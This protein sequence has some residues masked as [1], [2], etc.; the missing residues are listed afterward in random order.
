MEIQKLV[1]SPEGEHINDLAWDQ[2][3]GTLD[4]HVLEGEASKIEQSVREVVGEN[5]RFVEDVYSARELEAQAL[6]LAQS[7][8]D[9]GIHVVS[10]RTTENNSGLV[11]SVAESSTT[12][13][14]AAQDVDGLASAGGVPVVVETTAEDPAMATG[15]RWGDSSPFYGGARIYKPA[16]GYSCTSAFPVVAPITGGYQT[17]ILTADHCGAIGD[18]WRSGQANGNNW[19]L[20]TMQDGNSG[21]SDFK[22]LS[23]E[24]GA[25]IQG[26]VYTGSYT[27]STSLGVKARYY[28]I[29]GDIICPSGAY[30]GLN[31]LAEVQTTGDVLCFFPESLCYNNLITVHST[32]DSPLFG[33]GDSGG[34][35]VAGWNGG[36]L[37]MGVIT[38][39][40]TGGSN[41]KPCNGDTS[42]RSCS[43]VGYIAN[44]KAFF[45]NNPTWNLLGG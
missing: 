45:D 8:V 36:V 1:E 39:V 20:G 16:N 25:G 23:L 27:S 42:A 30:S 11:V 28:P 32:T 3:T 10:V 38:G 26:R 40:N 18:A 37:G 13:R 7:A 41:V 31:C 5:Y 19:A 29:A 14:R 9:A 6:E 17:A 43:V 15:W 22:R 2:A 21:G 35:V 33:K 24:N 12:Q 4:V 44:I 34:P